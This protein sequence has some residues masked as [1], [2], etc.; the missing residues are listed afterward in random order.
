MFEITK[1]QYDYL[2]SAVKPLLHCRISGTT[3]NYRFNYFYI[4]DKED[5]AA[6]VKYCD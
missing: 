4:G 1:K 5:F 6:R 3:G 2:L